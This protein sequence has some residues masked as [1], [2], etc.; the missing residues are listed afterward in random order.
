MQMPAVTARYGGKPEL[1]AKAHDACRTH[2]DH[3]DTCVLSIA[4]ARMLERVLLGQSVAVSFSPSTPL[5]N[6][7]AGTS[8][9]PAMHLAHMTSSC[10]VQASVLCKIACWRTGQVTFERPA[11]V[12][13]LVLQLCRRCWFGRQPMAVW[14]SRRMAW[15][16]APC[17]PR[18]SRT[19]VSSYTFSF[20]LQ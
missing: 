7:F 17:K 9:L 11:E 1:V 10:A 3:A 16:C 14:T 13:S 5:C 6:C 8:C 19:Q 20:I 4:F 12:E 15:C 2:Q 18:M